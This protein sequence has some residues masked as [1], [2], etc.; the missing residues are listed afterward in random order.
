VGEKMNATLSALPVKEPV[1]AIPVW[2][3]A[4]VAALGGLLFGFDTAVINGALV[5]L[6]RYFSMSD[7]GTELA[8][9]SLLAGCVLGAMITGVLSDRYGRRKLLI[10]AALCFAVSGIGAA[11]PHTFQQFVVARFVGGIAIGIASLVSPLYIA[12]ISP[13]R[14]RGRLVT[15][16][17]LMIV[18]GMLASF[19]VNYLVAGW[20]TNNWRWMFGSAALPSLFFLVALLLVPESP[21]W[22][23]EKGRSA[24]A[25]NI[26]TAID[27]AGAQ[28]ELNAIEKTVRVETGFLR[29]SGV[30]RPLAIAIALAVLQQVTGINTILYY[31]SL[32]FV[33]RVPG[34][35]DSSALMANI[36]IGA[37][38]LI[39][40][41]VAMLVVDRLGRRPLLLWASGGMGIS[42]T[43]LSIAIY[44]KASAPIILGTILLYVSCFAIGLGP[45]VWLV[46][47]EIF[48]NRVRGRAMSIATVCL[49]LAC[50]LITGTFL[51]LMNLAG[52]SATFL[53]YALMCA[54][55]FV[56][57]LSAVSET[58]GR[59]LEE[60]QETFRR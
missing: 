59:T 49:W 2:L 53:I 50:L 58:K 52:A 24:E 1:K 27:R 20:G 29:G 47:A 43:F 7:A 11:F 38:N 30:G 21:R 54:V 57:V 4:S 15:I 35:S 13:A 44:M 5:F 18:A 17:Q 51:T 3:P 8:A 12:E 56:L 55:T 40:T 26:L 25:L 45:G 28:H 37:V 33:E 23:V 10:G 22:L 16:N 48:P 42:L 39:C 32:L 14:I 9:S 41:I 46:M 31:G 34:Q 60:I 19:C 6:K 36:A